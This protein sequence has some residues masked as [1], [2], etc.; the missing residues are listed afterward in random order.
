MSEQERAQWAAGVE[1]YEP[2]GQQDVLFDQRMVDIGTAL[3]R[4][5]GK[6]NLD[7]TAG[8]ARSRTRAASTTPNTRAQACT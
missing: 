3:R 1:F 2:Y 8:I 5:E 4:A 7:E 6:S